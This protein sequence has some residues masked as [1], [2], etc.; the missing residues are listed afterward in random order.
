MSDA[1]GKLTF[2]DVGA[3]G[4]ISDGGVLSRSDLMHIIRNAD[5]Y[6]PASKTIGNGRNLPYVIVADDAFPLQKHIMKPHPY[7]SKEDWKQTF[8][9][10]LSRAR[11]NI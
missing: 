1:Y 3:N 8:N 11:Q 4:R 6:F 9:V 5:N 10:R 7:N 2:I